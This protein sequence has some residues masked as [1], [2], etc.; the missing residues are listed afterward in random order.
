[1]LLPAQSHITDSYPVEA[2]GWDSSQ[3]FFVEKSELEWNEA[4]GK[5]L[6][7]S[8]SLCPGSMIFLRLLQTMSPD[9]SLSVAYHAQP[10]GVTPQ[11]QQQ[12]RLNLIQPAGNSND[13]S[14]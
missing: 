1:M 3:C 4:T 6:K 2:S 9:R 5:H 13:K 14:E 8:R 10:M 7:L 11:G 12:F